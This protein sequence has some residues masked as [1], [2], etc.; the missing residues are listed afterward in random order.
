MRTLFLLLFSS[1]YSVYSIPSSKS[2]LST[3]GIPLQ[4]QIPSQ[5]DNLLNSNLKCNLKND[6][7]KCYL[8]DNWRYLSVS[9]EFKQ[10]IAAQVPD[11]SP[12]SIENKIIKT[13]TL[14]SFDN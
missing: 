11:L 10:K 2:S 8:E 4:I 5:I 7:Q 9:D 3:T 13:A 12:P 14:K 1:F 6:L